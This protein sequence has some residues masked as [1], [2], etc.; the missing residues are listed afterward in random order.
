MYRN[1]LANMAGKGEGGTNRESSIDVY[2]LPCVK[3]TMVEAAVYSAVFRDDLQG[4]MG[5]G[6]R[7][8]QEGGN[9]CMHG[10]QKKLTQHCKL[11]YT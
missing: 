9:T 7:E 4:G 1:G 11:L 2:T 8:T 6:E 3:T 10:I 5:G